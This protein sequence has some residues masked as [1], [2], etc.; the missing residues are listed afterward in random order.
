MSSLPLQ[1]IP[2]KYTSRCVRG[3]GVCQSQR[4][5]GEKI[6]KPPLSP[7]CWF[8]YSGEMRLY[9]FPSRSI[10]PIIWQNYYSKMY[11]PNS[12]QY[13]FA[14]NLCLS[15]DDIRVCLYENWWFKIFCKSDFVAQT[16]N[17]IAEFIFFHDSEAKI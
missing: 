8:V 5:G 11:I 9:F 1:K 2:L 17:E 13:P 12:Q 15:N 10:L 7:S 14:L 3:G 16:K 6:Q 4:G